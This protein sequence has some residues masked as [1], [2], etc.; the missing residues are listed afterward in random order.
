M[1]SDRPPRTSARSRNRKSKDSRK[2]LPVGVLKART[3]IVGFDEITN[4]GLPRGRTTLLE[5]GPGSGKTIMA[6]QTLVYGAKTEEEPG[7]FVAFEESPELIIANAETFD[8][9]FEELKSKLFFLNAKPAVDFVRSGSFDLGGM[10]AS[11]DAKVRAIK[12]QRIVFDAIDVVLALLNDPLAERREAFRLHE[13]LLANKLTAIITVK[14]SS[15]DMANQPQ[16]SFMEFMVDCSVILNHEVVH[17]VSQRSIRVVK[18]RGSAYAENESPLLIGQRGLEVAAA[19]GTGPVEAPVTTERV[20]SGVARLDVMLGGG[21]FRGATV[22]ITGFPGTAKSTLSGAF[23]EAACQRGE[24]TLFVSFDSSS[25]ELIRNLASV[26]INLERFIKKGVLRV[27]SAR[28]ITGNAEIHMMRIKNLAQEQGARCLVIDPVSAL[29]K[30]SNE[31]TAHSVAERLIDWTKI[32]GI[33]VLCTSLLDE[34]GPQI[35]GTPIEVS[36]IADTWIHLNYLVNA[37]ERNRGLS[38]IKSRGTAHSNQVRELMLSDAGV[39]LADA[40][41]AGGEVVMGTLRWEKERAVRAAR[42]ESEALE[43][44]QQATLEFEETDLELRLKAAQ[45][46]LEMKRAEKRAS[47]HSATDHSIDRDQERTHLRKLRGVDKV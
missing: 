13:W 15:Y 29:A 7:I 44:R 26:R 14:S 19:P 2:P 23:A 3:G 35:E 11:L 4:G 30:R 10:L 20:S 16:L 22:L 39:T 28:T 38:I 42:E 31:I 21:Y 36:T 18:Y 47:T 37:G 27:I 9:K 41:T 40:Y 32:K 1:N 34:S 33:T 8:W 5:G 12:A 17:G 25:N 43:K 24:P 6:L 45:R 46:E